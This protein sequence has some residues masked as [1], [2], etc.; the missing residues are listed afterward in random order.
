M[1]SVSTG[2][3]GIAFILLLIIAVVA[4]IVPAF[5]DKEAEEGVVSYIAVV[6]KV[7]QSGGQEA[8]SL[9]LFNEGKLASGIV[10]VTLLKDGN[11][12]VGAEK[13]INGKGTI[14][15]KVPAVAEGD[16]TIKVKGAGF[17]DQA[18]V[19]I[20][21]AVLTFLET[22]K[23]I[24]K[25]GQTIHIRAI[26]L[27]PELMPSS[28][29]VTVEALDAKGIKIFRSETTTDEYGMA[30][31][32][33]P[34]SQEPNLGVWKIT[35]ASAEGKT[36]IDVR[37][38]EYVLP[39]YEVKV[40]LPKEWFLVNEPIKGSVAAEYSFGKPVKGEL[41]IKASKYVGEWK[42]YATISKTIDYQTD[43][44]LPA[45]GYVA[46]TPAAGGMGNVMLEVTVKENA[47][48]Y[49]E[50]TSE[51]LTVASTPVNIQII[52]EGP[53]F[54]PGL[55]FNLLI[56]TETPDNEPVDARV[57]MTVTY[58][59][60]DFQEEDKQEQ[61]VDTTNG[62]ALVE[63]TAPADSVAMVI[64]AFELTPVSSTEPAQTSKLVQ[65]GYSPSGNFIHLEQISEGTPKVG[66]EIRFKVHSTSEAVN[67][68]YEVVAR[69][70]VV[71]TDFTKSDEIAFDVTPLM[72]PSA[73]LLVYQILPNSEVAA[74]YLPFK[75]EAVYP[76]NVIVEFSED[77]AAPGDGVQ[78]NIQA[79]GESKVGL[80]AVDKSVYILAGN[81][82]NMQQVFDEL[83][84]LYMEPQAELHEISIYEGI[85]VKGAK[86]IFDD[87]GV[88]VL[89]DS[90]I[91]EGEQY[92]LEWGPGIWDEAIRFFSGA[93]VK[94]MAGGVVILA[95]SA[96]PGPVGSQV[97]LAEVQRIRQYFPETWIW[98]E[99]VT[100]PD[101]KATVQVEVPD[102]IT[103]WMLR[104]VA[105]SKSNGLG[106][107]E[108][109][110]TAFQPFFLSVDLPYS[111]IRGEEFPVRIAVYN[112]LDETQ[113]VQVQIEDAEWFDLLDVSEKTID[114]AANEVG[115]VEFMISPT[116]LGINE[117]KVSARSTQAADA[118]IKTLIVAP[119]GVAREFVENLVLSA[120]VNRVVDTSIPPFVVADSGR[121]YIAVT[122]SYLTQTIEG[123]EGLIQMPF[124]CG[125]QNMIV[126]APD[127]YIT[128]YLT[129][130]GQ[131]KPE[132][133][134]K[135]EK[136]MITGYQRELVYRR[137]DGSFSAFGESDESG[138]LFLTAFVLKC[139]SQAED[140]IYIDDSILD[141]AEDWIISHQ[142]ADGSFDQVGFV[143]HQEMLGGLEGKTA[144]TAY[145]AVAL[146]ESGEQAASAKAI[147]YLEGQLDEID[148]AYT[149]AIA[150]YALEL[151]GSALKDQAYNKLMEMAEEDENGLHWGD[152]EEPIPLK[153]ANPW[154]FN[155][156]TVIEATGYATLALI[157]HG[158]ALNASK[159]A[160]W[161]VSQRN[162][163]GGY[164]STQDTVVALQALTE[165]ATDARADVDLTVTI[166]AGGEVNQ[167]RIKQ[168][169]FDV[170]Q[171]VEVP[172][173]AEVTINAEGR[174]EVIAQVVTRFN[175]PDEE[176][177]E[178]ILK[179]SVDY[180]TTEVEVND[181]VKV[182][183]GLE[184]APPIEMKAGM[185]V[186]DVSVPTGFAPVAE[187]VAAVVEGN[188][189]IKRYEIAGRKVIFYIEDMEAGD[190]INFSFDVKAL[191]PVK[192]KGVASQAYSYY[193]P[194]IKAETLG[195]G[196]V[197]TE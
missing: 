186:L 56:I 110:L 106:I 167:L 86:D 111:A 40:E 78:I 34:I 85:D 150:A 135:A 87:A 61:E 30:T 96:V 74:D 182:S 71:F 108:D 11:K 45:A 89:S 10:E 119:E 62:K 189:Q 109:Q 13:R 58:L 197:V 93:G 121:A 81:R 15:F 88:V 54:K 32:E 66:E 118:V 116:K 162:A 131:L 101:G 29:P 114:I 141:E 124:G 24:Y 157:K 49:Q 105:L 64:E 168:D 161:L 79:E 42:E 193:N 159:A 5:T 152:M 53:V 7:L 171:V 137:S 100:G 169:N 129:E 148:D 139:F 153:E 165:Y 187:S 8:V 18:N 128:K 98:Q 132:I 92:K 126:F 48:G 50:S 12:V 25:P 103:T 164:G 143:H 63:V 41:V 174:G 14:E 72:A 156:S 142:N 9:T 27:N 112:Y 130:S 80:V 170:L 146:L 166:T 22:D 23:P 43:F 173:N 188:E 117:M 192:A 68:Y 195:E 172:V 180:D 90:K 191:Y 138:S 125:E 77:E 75:A 28:Q 177:G 82:L 190:K 179:I 113:S 144:L 38:E 73:K 163:Y 176:K 26:T 122:S 84:R 37:V 47:T 60:K 83:E 160:K 196:I 184:F 52:P 2:S 51:L 59:N 31:L 6:P 57:H 127:V 178:E 97:E 17:E 102:S 21:K 134:A 136:L 65:A 55:P 147:S 94:G 4:P 185:V 39:K 33:L 3:I 99:V 140:L 76:H 133:M 36:Q 120:G 115:G 95:P 158:D 123:L 104:A 175:L 194:D 181:L 149:M 20:E 35:A 183:V 151:G 19:K 69:D 44:E 107:A 70:R 46:G 67:F 155:K 1:K 154:E 145:V 91:P 16:Y